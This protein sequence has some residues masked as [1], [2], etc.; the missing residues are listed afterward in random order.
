M[1]RAPAL[2]RKPFFNRYRKKPR[3]TNLARQDLAGTVGSIATGLPP[4]V[5]FTVSVIISSFY[6]TASISSTLPRPIP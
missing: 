3:G 4:I 2:S 6:K 5:F 1:L